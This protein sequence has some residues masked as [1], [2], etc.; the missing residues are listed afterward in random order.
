VLVLKAGNERESPCI[1]GQKQESD[2]E[3]GEVSISSGT[4]RATVHLSNSGELA[5]SGNVKVNGVTLET[6]IR[7][8]LMD[9]LG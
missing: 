5:L 2:L 8:T 1:V 4:G 9:I 7:R 6:M 3:P